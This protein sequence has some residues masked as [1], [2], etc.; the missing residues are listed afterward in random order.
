VQMTGSQNPKNTKV[1]IQQSVSNVQH[2]NTEAHRK[3]P[4]Q[5]AEKCETLKSKQCK[6]TATSTFTIHCTPQ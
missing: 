1:K 6:K 4:L 2:E 3:R 5:I